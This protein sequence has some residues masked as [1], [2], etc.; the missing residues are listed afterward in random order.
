MT[1]AMVLVW[2]AHAR[3][4]AARAASLAGVPIAVL[5]VYLT[6][7]RAGAAGVGV[8]VLVALGLSV[9]RWTVAV[10]ALVAAGA[11]AVVVLAVRDH[12]EIAEGVGS[13]GA[14]AVL[15]ALLGAM[16][17]C[18]LCAF[19]TS[20]LGTDRLRLDIRVAR[21]ATPLLVFV[22]VLGL[23]TL[24][25]EPVSD[26]WDD[27]RNTGV[28][29]APASAPADP[30]ARLTTLKGSR[31]EVYSS[32]LRAFRD[33]PLQGIGPGTFEFYWNR[34]GG[35]QFV[36]D[37]HS[38]YIEQAAE[39]GLPGALLT[40]GFLLAIGALGL[41]ARI[42]LKDPSHAG[43]AAALCAAFIV[44]LFHAGVDWMWESTAVTVLAL[45]AIALA[46]GSVRRSRAAPDW[47]LRSTL[48]AAAV[49]ACAVAL[50]GLLSTLKLRASREAFMGGNQ[51]LA[52]SEAD[53][54]V[55]RLP[56]AAGPYLQ[57]GLV[58][59]A[60]GDLPAAGEDL[61][62]A[63]DRE[64]LNWR[65]PLLLARLEAEQGHTRASIRAFRDAKRL[66]PASPFLV[67]PT[68]ASR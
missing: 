6:Y 65:P 55:A 26:A 54:A 34:D 22:A 21:V 62:R 61:R 35:L 1:V 57:R 14:G 19:A 42:R 37:A 7:S 32:A 56:S 3:T 17:L 38:V 24:G 30:S 33:E 28:A 39:L 2:S 15:T 48:I 43:A 23:A 8:A 67:P 60:Q 18:A 10:H 11:S 20:L 51:S 63:K 31:Y 13:A 16:L 66:R 52:H 29:T 9:N 58:R 68:G 64:P 46:A 50:P 45:A 25:R 5:A 4:S 27:F 53:A 49:C 40:V 59:W 12:R 47:R 41:A 44:F 36:R